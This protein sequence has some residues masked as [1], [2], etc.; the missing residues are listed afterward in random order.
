MEPNDVE[1]IVF[2]TVCDVFEKLSFMFGE[3][4]APDELPEPVERNVKASM[5][6]SGDMSGT[7]S[8]VVPDDVCP[9][10]AANVLGT[11]QDD[12]IVTVQAGDA[13]K[14]MLNVMCG[15]ILTAIAGEEPVFDL[16]VPEVSDVDAAGW[17]GLVGDEQTNVLLVDDS[18][19]L[20][21]FTIES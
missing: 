18:P 11:D 17:T 6:Y 3:L 14:E 2:T 4:A 1:E 13:L 5:T 21:Q 7:F 8:I 15:N 9:E 19:V 16:S 20:V 10:I 12:E